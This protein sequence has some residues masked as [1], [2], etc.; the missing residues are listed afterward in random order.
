MIQTTA[1]IIGDTLISNIRP[2]FK[3]IVYC[4]LSGGCS[5]DVS[6]FHPN[7]NNLSI[8]LYNVL[9]DDGFSDYM[10]AGSE[11]TKMPRGDKTQIMRYPIAIPSDTV[12]DDFMGI[13]TPMNEKRLLLTSESRYLA[14]L[15]DA[16][17]PR[18]M[19]GE[20]S[21]KDIDIA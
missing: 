14:V 11:G 5:T 20:L 16:L 9:Y 8:Y 21:V 10:V 6:C 12:L 1:F 17:L 19:S 7:K 4:G 3:K 13:V 2:Y 15:C 18:L